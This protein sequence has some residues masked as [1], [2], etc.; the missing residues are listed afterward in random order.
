MAILKWA[1]IHMRGKERERERRREGGRK[2]VREEQLQLWL[3]LAFTLIRG[4]LVQMTIWVWVSPLP[5]PISFSPL[6]PPPTRATLADSQ[7]TWH[8]VSTAS[9]ATFHISHF[10]FHISTFYICGN[11]QRSLCA[12]CPA[13]GTVQGLKGGGVAGA[14]A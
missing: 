11:C 5:S 13:R 14:G 8:L 3:V 4:L 7:R 9:R 12:I 10:P 6:S 1:I 2:R